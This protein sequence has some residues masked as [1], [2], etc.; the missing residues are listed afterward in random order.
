MSLIKI[1]GWLL[2]GRGRGEEEESYLSVLLYLGY[3]LLY[4]I[5][6]SAPKENEVG[7]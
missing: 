5:I 4:S 6:F 2:G 7:H 3:P 1:G